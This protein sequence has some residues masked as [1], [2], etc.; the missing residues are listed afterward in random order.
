VTELPNGIVSADWFGDRAVMVTLSSG[1]HRSAVLDSLQRQFP[2]LVVRAGMESVLVEAPRPAPDLRAAVR[3][4]V[5]RVAPATESTARGSGAVTIPVS[6]EGA[7]LSFV[8]EALRANVTDVVQAHQRQLWTVAMMGFAPGFGYLVPLGPPVLDWASLARRDRP[9][10]EVPTGSV[11]VAAGMSAVYPAAMPGG[12]HL[13]GRT[14]LR[15]FD[16]DADPEPTAL[17]PGDQVRF[18][19]E[20]GR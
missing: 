3:D 20:H 13:I 7:D 12:W 8:A 19:E 1:E 17:H 16:A 10:H 14:T 9:R 18:R 11:A 6:Y 4:A 2:D 15:L 5:V